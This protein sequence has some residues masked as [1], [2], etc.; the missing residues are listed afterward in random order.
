MDGSLAADDLELLRKRLDEDPDALAVAQRRNRRL[1]T[2]LG[3]W[4]HIACVYDDE[5]L[6]VWHFVDGERVYSFPFTKRVPLHFGPV[7]LGNWVPENLRNDR[8]WN[9]NGRVD[10]DNGETSVTSLSVRPRRE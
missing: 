9:L 3:R 5:A 7:E 4:M 10:E 8:I 1:P 2:D 6:D